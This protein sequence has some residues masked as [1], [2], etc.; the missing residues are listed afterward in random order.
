MLITA[1][2]QRE[3]VIYIYTFFFILWFNHRISN[4]VPCAMWQNLVVYP[5][6]VRPEFL[7]YK[8]KLPFRDG[9]VL[10]LG[11]GSEITESG[12]FIR[13]IDQQ[14][15]NQTIVGN[16]ED[17]KPWDF[18]GGQGKRLRLRL[19]MQGGVGSFPGWKAKIQHGSW[20]KNQIIKQKHYCNKF[21]RL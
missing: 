7:I 17:K 11:S 3:S 6:Y 13:S 20:P 5:F 21:N 18:L 4:I 8:R 12:L 2:Q 16:D 1:V 9:T 14:Q 19:P 15:G 10:I